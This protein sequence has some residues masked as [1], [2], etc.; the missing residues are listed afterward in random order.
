MRIIHTR[1]L[2]WSRGMALTPSLILIREDA[3]GDEALLAHERE[4]CEQMRRLGTVWFWLRY[5]TSAAF[6]QRVEVDA[7]RVSYSHAPER[8]AAYATALSTRYR[9]R[10]TFE[11]AVKLIEGR[12]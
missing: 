9:L 6:R 5:I 3:R 8:I 11:Q 1:L 10:L 2:T 12:S 4:H 7:Y